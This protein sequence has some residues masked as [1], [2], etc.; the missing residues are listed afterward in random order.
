MLS[1]VCL[2]Q[3][4]FLIG[5]HK[6]KLADAKYIFHDVFDTDSNKLIDKFELMSGIIL[7]SAM[8][9][10]EKVECL[11]DMFDFNMK[12]FLIDSEVV[13]LLHTLTKCASKIDSKMAAPSMDKLREIADF[14]MDYCVLHEHS[15]RKY[16]LVTFAADFPPTR[17]FLEAF[18]GHV[19]QVLLASY[20]LW[21]DLQFTAQHTSIAPSIEWLNMGLPPHDFVTWRRR[22]TVSKGC[23][24]IFGHA[25]KYSKTCDYPLME[26][27]GALAS[28]I[29]QQGL[30]A[31]RWVMNAVAVYIAQPATLRH[32]FGTTGQENVGR[33]CVRLFEGRGWKSIFVDDR[34]PC[35]PVKY[36]LFMRSSCDNE[37]WPMMLEKGIAKSLGS[38]GHMAACGIR[39]DSTEVAMKW[40]SGGH[41]TKLHVLEYEWL[42]IPQE[43]TGRDGAQLCQRILLEGSNISFGKSE[44]RMFHVTKV[45]KK[46]GKKLTTSKWTFPFGRLFPLLG[47]EL[48]KHYKYFVFRDAW[49]LVPHAETEHST[50]YGHIRTFKVRLEDIPAEFDTMFFVRFP[51]S[52]KA[53]VY[54]ESKRFLMPKPYYVPWVTEV[55]NQSFTNITSPARFFVRVF[56]SPEEGVLGR[57]ENKKAKSKMSKEAVE[58]AF[59]VS[60]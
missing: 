21:Q 40:I 6:L 14:S 33:F 57:K 32:L 24:M 54:K 47:I 41:V 11:Y 38:Y 10:E 18:R 20:Q 43:V 36:P 34:I 12:G 19:S 7:L 26:G 28:G 3:I 30:L 51:D 56:D 31:D 27:E 23:E 45:K 9:S 50:E 58:I 16:E 48:I 25:E 52:I 29:L 1:V 35:D 39:H 4:I 17:A 37:C 8:S 2:M 46:K 42:T 60:W 53:Q 5:R 15:L 13:L 59:S 49:G 44:P 22:K 55:L